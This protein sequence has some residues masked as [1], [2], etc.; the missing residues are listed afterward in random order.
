MRSSAGALARCSRSSAA[1]PSTSRKG[2][3]DRRRLFVSA[4]IDGAQ[5][6]TLSSR[7]T[8]DAPFS[9][10][11]AIPELDS[12]GLECCQSLSEDERVIVF[13]STRGGAVQ[14]YYATRKDRTDRF[15]APRA[16]PIV[17]PASGFDLHTSLSADG[18]TLYLSST[19]PG[20]GGFDL[21]VSGIGN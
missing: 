8:T 10:P 14:L 3:Q 12:T 13:A 15:L 17:F 19:R 9:V 16:V 4:V 2:S 6:I 18:C 11:V 20:V 21:W 7:T 5:H 1:W